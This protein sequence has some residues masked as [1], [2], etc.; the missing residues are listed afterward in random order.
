MSALLELQDVK[1]SFALR[2]GRRLQAVKGV[3]IE[4][5]AG[6]TLG[7]VG[8]SGCGKSTLARC[9]IG[10]HKPDSGTIRFNG[11]ELEGLDRR[12]LRAVRR[13]LTMVF[14]DPYASL[15]PRRTV[16][17]IV[18]APLDIHDIGTRADRRK[19]VLETL[20]RV[21]LSASHAKRYPH[22]FS[23]GQRQRIGLARALVTQPKLVVLDEPVSA[24]DVS[25]QAQILNL[26]MDLQQELN[27]TLV[28][29]AHDLGVVRHI[30]QEIAVMYLGRIVEQA[31]TDELFTNP[32]HHYSA[33]LLSAVPTPDP[34]LS[35]DDS[36]LI[37]G[38]IANVG[39]ELSGCDF[40]PRCPAAID[41]CRELVPDLIDLTPG[42]LA[43]CHKPVPEQQLVPAA[44]GRS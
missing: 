16:A 29:I 38:D 23:G 11:E 5:E 7:L 34:H 13:E 31:A 33:G 21:G 30:S 41:R 40:C 39:T 42:H 37:R 2:G 14:Q 9:I 20:E 8:E 26:L 27:L 17:D 44:L 4:V 36:A 12:S 6:S 28:L 15:N 19:Q 18:A 22:E 35:G 10:L 32:R 1:M 24:L 3:S 43:A 25:V